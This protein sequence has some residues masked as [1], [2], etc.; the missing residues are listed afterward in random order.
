MKFIYSLITLL[1]LAVSAFAVEIPKRHRVPNRDPG[2]CCW[3]SL[4]T[5]GRLHGVKALHN[6]VERRTH[7]SGVYVLTWHG[8]EYIP[9]NVGCDFVVREKLEDLG[10]RFR[11]QETGYFSRKLLRYATSHGC[12]VGMQRG[13]FEGLDGQHAVTLTHY[14]DECV[15][16]IDP[17]H[18]EQVFRATREWFDYYWMGM[19][20]VIL[21]DK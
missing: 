4:E 10:V 8:W 14:D 20:I 7:E 6:L 21:D 13:A 17:N 18:P 12:T 5:L 2:Y 16:F 15:E 11:Q 1:A 19:V 3:A 9:N